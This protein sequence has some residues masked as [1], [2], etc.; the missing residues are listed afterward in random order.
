M[1]YF[2]LAWRNIWRNKKRTLIT[3]GS[4]FFALILS[5]LMIGLQK[6]V[7][8]NVIKVSVEDFSGYIQVHKKGYSQDKNLN[9]TLEY[10]KEIKDYLL[11]NENVVVL[12]PRIE[13][14]CLSA[15]GDKTKGIPIIGVN[16]ELEFEK[17]GLKKRLVSGE[18]PST[19]SGGILIPEKYAEYMGIS[20]GDSLAFIGQGYH[21]ISAVALCKVVGIIRM[22]NPILNSGLAYMEL[23]KAQEIFSLENRVSSIVV[24][25]G[26]SKKFFET[27]QELL[28]SL[29]E[30][31]EILTWEEEMPELVQ[32]I[33][34][35]AGGTKIILLILYIVVGFGIFGTAL[36]MIAERLKEFAIMIA[37]GMHKTKIIIVV[38]L[39]MIFISLVG[40]IASILVSFPMMYYI[41]LHPFHLKGEMA[42]TYESIGFEP[43]IPIAW[44]ISYYWIQPIIVLIITLIA[45]SYPL[46]SIRKISLI[47]AMKK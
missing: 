22:P 8:N 27:N 4:V 6:G 45:I 20:I 2:K 9:N 17:E 1:N 34:S 21:G 16:P 36:M 39:E 18:F 31:Y 10:N 35:K 24:G 3:A 32:L 33:E 38:V 43:I 25:L 42:S 41:H 15:F 14:F 23:G 11:A 5:I 46:Y 40:I 28:K 12:Y 7:F 30:E 47:K 37:I 26:K 13:T 19:Q 44:D 29:P